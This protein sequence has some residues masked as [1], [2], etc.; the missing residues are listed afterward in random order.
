MVSMVSTMLC[1]RSSAP[2]DPAEQVEVGDLGRREELGGTV[3]ARGH[4][5][6]QPMHA[7]AS[8]AASA[9]SLAR[10]S[11]WRRA[12]YRGAEMNPPASMMWSSAVRSVERSRITGN[13]AARH[14]ST[15]I[16]SPSANL[17][18]RAGRSR[19]A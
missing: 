8:M 2:A 4:A 6:A 15:V 7:A 12:R 11:G 18:R 9:T 14:G 13:A 19:A 17:R 5:C 3:R 16:S 10:G 1:T